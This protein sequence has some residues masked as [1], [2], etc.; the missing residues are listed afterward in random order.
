VELNDN[1]V[2]HWERREQ[3][4]ELHKIAWNRVLEG[5]DEFDLGDT[6]GG[7]DRGQGGE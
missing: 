4:V 7:R 1:G 2:A 6:V 5:A 3:E